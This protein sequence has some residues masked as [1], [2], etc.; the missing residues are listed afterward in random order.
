M[1]EWS[2]EG[3]WVGEYRFDSDRVDAIHATA[4]TLH[5]SPGWFGRFRGTVQD[6]DLYRLLSPRTSDV[7]ANEYVAKDGKEAV[8]FAFRHAQR[9]RGHAGRGR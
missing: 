3:S 8:L 5:L 1:A 4:F 2:V 9:F 6:G 7:T